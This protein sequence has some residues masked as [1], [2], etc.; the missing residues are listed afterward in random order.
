MSQDKLCKLCNQELP[1]HNFK[2]GKN[3][4]YECQ[5][6][7]SRDWKAR[8]RDK[9][10]E[11]SRQ[12]K[13][14]NQDKVSVYN[15]NYNL[16]NRENIQLRSSAY[17]TSRAKIDPSFKLAKS[18][19]NRY[20]KVLKDGRLDDSSM[21]LLGCSID[22]FRTWL[23]YRF[24]EVMTFENYGPIW[25]LD[26]V[27]PVCKFNLTDENEVRK[28]FHWSNFQP[29]HSFENQK[30]SG[31]ISETEIIVHEEY[32]QA[33]LNSLPEKERN[34]YSIVDIDRMSYTKIIKQRSNRG[35]T[36][37]DT[38]VSSG[39]WETKSVR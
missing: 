17:H 10:N 26:H 29:L 19:R 16:Q 15:S 38:E 28:C 2:Y 21:I 33:F 39:D 34:Q 31:K 9:T 36:K 1:L 20:R 3:S 11:Y 37:D 5:K 27:V 4:C 6:R 18:L 22:A 24:D 14:A 30:K 7:M 13:L 32:L 23:Q 25:H 8:N 12:W 35:A